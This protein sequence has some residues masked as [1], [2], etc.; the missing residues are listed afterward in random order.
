[1]TFYMYVTYIQLN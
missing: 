1:M